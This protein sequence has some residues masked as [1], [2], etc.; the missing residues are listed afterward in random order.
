MQSKKEQKK[1]YICIYQVLIPYQRLL[2]LYMQWEKLYKL[3]EGN[4]SRPKKAESGKRREHN[5]K[6]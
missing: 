6:A 1:S 3:K 2:T 5:L 4:E